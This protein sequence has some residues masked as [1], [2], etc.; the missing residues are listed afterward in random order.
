M[1]PRL[2]SRK[3]HSALALLAA[4]AMAMA[5]STATLKAAEADAAPS[6]WGGIP[7][8]IVVRTTENVTEGGWVWLLKQAKDTGITRIYLL[9]KQDENDYQSARTKRTLKSG[10]LLVAL[11]NETTAEGWENSDWLKEMLTKAHAD[12]IEVFA[13]YP[14]FQDA[15]LA[16]D[17]PDHVYTGTGKEAFVDPALP[18]VRARQDALIAK[19]IAA[20]PF[21]GVALDWVRYNSRADGSKGPL[22]ERFQALTG[23]PW[24]EDAMKQ[25]LARATWDDLRAEVVAD[26]IGALTATHRQRNP[27][28]KWGAFVLPWQ[29]KEV[30]QS[31]RRLGHAGLDDLQPMIYWADWK[32]QPH[33][34]RE[35]LRGG[36]FWLGD[37][38]AFRPTFDLNGDEAE[39]LEGIAELGAYR[40]SGQ[41]WYLHEA[42]TDKEFARLGRLRAKWIDA[43]GPAIETANDIVLDPPAP[44]PAKYP[45]KRLEPALFAADASVWTLVCL[46]DLYKSGTL[47]ATD[48]IVP[49]LAFHRFVDGAHQSGKTDWI[50]STAYLD[51]LF[52]FL[53]QSGFSTVSTSSLLGYMVSEDPTILPK[54][55][56]AL[57]IDDGSESILKHF[58][59]RAE[60]NDFSYAVSLITSLVKDQANGEMLEDYEQRDVILTSDQVRKMHATG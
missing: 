54:Q 34:T 9:V 57:T 10:E 51:E 39:L 11:P 5:F 40:L 6:A 3:I 42:W 41:T 49:V 18:A 60:A 46:A 14:V 50:N 27:G 30:S 28:L 55:P 20:Y 21:D 16:R 52:A 23:Q 32:E 36:P 56:V 35:V 37:K 19:L 48:K 15:V 24:S 45:S 59:P 43:G 31:Y 53:K 26:W 13:W 38:T 47:D 12:G 33:W 17:F 44:A 29:F 1:T 7:Q 22:A 8:A 4:F 25:P 2:T 58:H